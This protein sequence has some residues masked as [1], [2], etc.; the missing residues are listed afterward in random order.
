M[1]T[2]CMC[3][4]LTREQALV[5]FRVAVYGAPRGLVILNGLSTRI[6]GRIVSSGVKARLQPHECVQPTL[7]A[8]CS[9]C[10]V[11]ACEGGIR[12]QDIG[13]VRHGMRVRWCARRNECGVGACNVIGSVMF[14]VVCLFMWEHPMDAALRCCMCSVQGCI[15]RA[16]LPTSA[17]W[18]MRVMLWVFMQ[19]GL[20]V[21][22]RSEWRCLW[23]GGGVIVNADTCSVL[24]LGNHGAVWFSVRVR[25]PGVYTA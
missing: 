14:N 6:Q 23:C 18:V 10:R 24:A 7:V 19:C 15:L 11:R 5:V 16:V 3:A 13:I 22:A 20:F 12:T 8:L 1:V 9:V 4:V 21:H 2:T 25:A 17:T